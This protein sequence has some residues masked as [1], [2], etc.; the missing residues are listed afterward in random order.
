MNKISKNALIIMTKNPVL[1]QCKTRLAATIGD[2]KALEIYT[3]LLDYTAEFSKDIGVDRFIYSTGKVIDKQRWEDENTYFR[4]QV[5]NDLGDK[6]HNAIQEIFQEGYDKIVLIGSDC[7][8]I[9]SADI[10]AAF[11]QL[12]KHKITLGPALD[13]GYYLIGM[14]E[15]NPTLFQNIP[16][17]TSSVIKETFAK[18]KA[19]KLSCFL[20][21]EKSDIDVES[22]LQR[23]GFVEFKL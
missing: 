23:K 16:W 2:E 22:D 11:Q 10:H 17:S 8:E 14:K 5:G 18:I 13:G 9:N 12:N 4:T 7:T 21:E 19:E 20:L 15:T 6:M 1:G 3:Q